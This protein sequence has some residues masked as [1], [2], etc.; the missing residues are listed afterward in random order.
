MDSGDT[1]KVPPVCVTCCSDIK[2]DKRTCKYACLALST[3]GA[4]HDEPWV[5]QV[6]LAILGAVHKGP[7]AF[8]LYAVGADGGVDGHGIGSFGL[9]GGAVALDL[10]ALGITF[11]GKC[12]DQMFHHCLVS[13]GWSQTQPRSYSEK[14]LIHFSLF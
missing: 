11:V 14:T 3:F 9:L 2:D 6:P 8:D 4:R 12:K 5:R 13:W 1:S 7:P 10:A